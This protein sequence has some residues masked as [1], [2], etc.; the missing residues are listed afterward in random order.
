MVRARVGRRGE[1][2]RARGA[3][4]DFDAPRPPARAAP[5]SDDK[6]ATPKC[7][8]LCFTTA[9]RPSR[10]ACAHTPG[11]PLGKDAEHAALFCKAPAFRRPARANI[12]RSTS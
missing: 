9:L 4:S 7:A 12:C 8:C 6:S 11:A 2:A 10:R 5:M 1:R 3:E